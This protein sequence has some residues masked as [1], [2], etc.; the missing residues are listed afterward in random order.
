MSGLQVAFAAP[1]AE[2]RA[3]AVDKRHELKGQRHL[4]VGGD[5]PTTH[6]RR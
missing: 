3:F 1:P 4:V 5:T 2:Y 6:L